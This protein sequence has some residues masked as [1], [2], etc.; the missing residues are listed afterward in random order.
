MIQEVIVTTQNIDG[1]T[2]L[3]PMGIHIIENKLIILPFQPSTT[4]DNILRTQTA[5]INYTDDVRIFAG[6][7]T[8]R[9]QWNLSPTLKIAGYYLTTALAHKEVKLTQVEDDPIRP[10]LFCDALYSVNHAPFQGF[11][12]AQFA[13]LEAAILASRLDR[14]SAEKIHAEL[15]YLQI[16]IDKTAGEY[17]QQAWDWLMELINQHTGATYP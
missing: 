12:R 10:R 9:Y 7:L 2:H 11:N 13:V 3:A 1:T 16:A 15:A 4:L 6:C 17:E 5:V 8:G 14:L